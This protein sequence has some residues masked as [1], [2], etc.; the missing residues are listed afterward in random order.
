MGF[1]EGDVLIEE[2]LGCKLAGAIL[3][4]MV[5][6]F[7]V[8]GVSVTIWQMATGRATGNPVAV[9]LFTTVVL[10]WPI[11]WGLR[12]FFVRRYFYLKDGIM[13][14]TFRGLFM[15]KSA[16]VNMSEYKCLAYGQTDTESGADGHMGSTARFYVK[17]K[18]PC[19]KYTIQF[20]ERIEE[21]MSDERILRHS[22]LLGL[23]PVDETPE[24]TARFMA[25]QKKVQEHL[26][27]RKKQ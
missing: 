11:L 2:G 17:A 26:A 5:A 18:H 25:F 14:F 27:D 10:V 8:A 19:R 24:K 16:E 23:T 12:Q 13:H 20:Y 21:Q 1:D 7:Y 4:A 22:E 3:L 9:I 6:P 15:S